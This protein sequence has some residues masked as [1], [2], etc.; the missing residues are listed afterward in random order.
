MQEIDFVVTWLNESDP[1]WRRSREK[2][3]PGEG[4]DGRAE[5]YRDWGLFRYWFRGVE[6][7]APW[8]R[9][10]HLVTWGHIP[11]WLNTDCPRLNVVRHED[12]IPAEFLPT[13]NG[14]VIEIYLYRIRGLAEQFVYF[15]DDMYLTKPV[16]P[17]YFFRGGLPCDMLALQPVVANRDNP[18]MSH[19]FLN[20]ALVLSKYFDKREN[21]RRQPGSY[22]HIGYPPLYF[23]YNFLELFFPRFTGFY[24]VHG[25][26]P[27]LKSTF[28][29]LWEK[30]GEA[31]EKMSANRFRSRDDLTPYLFREYQKLSGRFR[32]KNIQQDFAFFTVIG[33][34][35]RL[36]RTIRKQKKKTICINDVSIPENQAEEAGK[37]IRGAFQQILPTPS[38]FE[39]DEAAIGCRMRG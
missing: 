34:T 35:D 27:F 36:L 19:L 33:K 24:T 28:Q 39:Q 14:N 5:R 6:K 21:V 8:V 9:K 11:E 16:K 4:E 32:P 3:A 37:A 26:M 1:D 20:N 17:E 2:Y 23:C 22:F 15:N 18:V 29:E 38:V 13:F 25:P 10:V 12:I 31:L 30:E 7:F